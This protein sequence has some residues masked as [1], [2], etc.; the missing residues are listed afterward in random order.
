MLPCRSDE[1]ITRTLAVKETSRNNAWYVYVPS[2]WRIPT[3]KH[4]IDTK[5]TEE[6]F[7]LHLAVF[8]WCF[9]PQWFVLVL[10]TPKCHSMR[11]EIRPEQSLSAKF[12]NFQSK[13][14]IALKKAETNFSS[15]GIPITTPSPKL[16]IW[17]GKQFSI[18][19]KFSSAKCSGRDNLS[20]AKIEETAL[21]YELRAEWN[22]EWI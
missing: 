4:V 1:D 9:L 19:V 12:T 15:F 10:P 14:I 13:K 21:N 2:R 3:L 7:F 22:F 11:L 16:V 8:A 20:E 17:A 18:L 6:K 5:K